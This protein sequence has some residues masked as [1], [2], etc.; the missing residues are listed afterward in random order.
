MVYKFFE[1]LIYPNTDDFMAKVLY[2][3][4]SQFPRDKYHRAYKH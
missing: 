2:E 1:K 4:K 3:K